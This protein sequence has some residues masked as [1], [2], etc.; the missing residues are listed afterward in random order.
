MDEV[1]QLYHFHASR[2]CDTPSSPTFIKGSREW[3]ERYI[4]MSDFFDLF[5]GYVTWRPPETPSEQMIGEGLGVWGKRNVSRLR[6]MLRERG[7]EFEVINGEGP[8]QQL[9]VIETLSRS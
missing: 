6:R 1:Q 8:K 4:P 5:G 3:V 7:A 2:N 9:L